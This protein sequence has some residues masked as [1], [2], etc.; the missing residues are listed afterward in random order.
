MT[1]LLLASLVAASASIDFRPLE[2]GLELAEVQ[3]P[4]RSSVGDSTVTVLRIDPARFSLTLLA[5]APSTGSRSRTARA[6]VRN[7]GLAAAVNA[8]M[9]EPGGKPTGF[10]RKGSAVLNGRWKAGYQAALAFGPRKEGLPAVR[11]LD[12]DCDGDLQVASAGYEH[13]VQSIRMIDC[14]RRNA[15]GVRKQRYSS[16]IAAVDTRGRLL[17]LHCRSP[18]VMHDY[19][20]QLLSLSALDLQRALYLEGGPEASLYVE[21]GGRQVQRVGSFETGFNEN[22]ENRELWDLPNVIGVRRR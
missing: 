5:A 1:P 3:L 7:H 4:V 16:V 21:A 12:K 2:P 19:I 8:G 18:F 11:I 20:A 15:W 10:A 14:R 6:W 22:D 17:L 9:F 13:V